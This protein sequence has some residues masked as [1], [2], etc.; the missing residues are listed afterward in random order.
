MVKYDKNNV[1]AKI[2]RGELPC[3]KVHEDEN[4]IAFW[5]I[6]PKAPLHILALPKGEYI[7]YEDFIL[8]ASDFAIISLNKFIIEVVKITNLENGYRVITNKGKDSGQSVFH[9]HF[10]ILSKT[11]FQY[12]LDI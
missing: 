1:F 11:V 12:D 9:L 3:K 7:D 8:N 2:I 6:E 5:S 10:H 4:N